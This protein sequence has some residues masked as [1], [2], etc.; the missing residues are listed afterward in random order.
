MEDFTAIPRTGESEAAAL[1]RVLKKMQVHLFIHKCTN[2]VANIAAFNFVNC[3]FGS[4]DSYSCR[5]AASASYWA[6]IFKSSVI[7]AVVFLH[8]CVERC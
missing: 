6:R 3:D 4:V 2:L 8:R 1:I 5:R 7:K